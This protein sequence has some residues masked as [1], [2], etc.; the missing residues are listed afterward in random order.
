MVRVVCMD[1]ISRAVYLE[2]SLYRQMHV[3][4]QRLRSKAG[5]DGIKSLVMTYHP[6]EINVD[7]YCIGPVYVSAESN[8]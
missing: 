2:C 4:E 5:G 1:R 3:R 7:S 8:E 6:R